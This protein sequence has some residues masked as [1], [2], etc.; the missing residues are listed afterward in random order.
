MMFSLRVYAGP[1]TPLRLDRLACYHYAQALQL[2]QTRLHERDQTNV[3]SDATIMVIIMLA[4]TAEIMNEYGT[5]ENHIRGL[6]KIVKLRGGVKALTTHT[7]M[8]VKVCR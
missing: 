8:P 3:V 5:V 4:S 2:L 1:F 6:E 7:N